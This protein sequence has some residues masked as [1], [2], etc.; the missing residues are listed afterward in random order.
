LSLRAVKSMRTDTRWTRRSHAVAGVGLLAGI[1]TLTGRPAGA[2]PGSTER[3]S[4]DSGGNQSVG[5]SFAG[6]F[7]SPPSI[8][9][10]G[11]F[12]AFAAWARNLAPGDTNGFGDVFVRDRGAGVT[13]RLSVDGAG[14]E[15]ND[16]IH[17]PALSADGRFV[18][19]VSAA[20]NLVPGDTN[21]QSD[22]FVHDRRT[23]TTER[24]SVASAGSEGSGWSDRPAI[25]AD[26]RFVAFV[27]AAPDLVPGD[28]NGRADVFVHDRQTRTTERVNVDS[29]GTQADGES[30]SPALSA[31]G[32]FVAFVS[33]ATNLVPGDTNGRADVFVHDR[34]TRTTERVSVDSAGTQAD[35][36]S[37]SPALS[38]DGRFVAFSSGATNLVPGDTNGQSDVFVHD[39]QTRAT[40]RVSVDSAGT[41]ADGWSDRPAIS[42]GGRF[43]AFC[44]FATNLM[45]G[46]TN[47]QWDEFVHDRQTR[48]TE[49]VSVD[50]AGTEANASSH[51]PSISAGGR[52]VVFAS[53]ATNLVPGDTNWVRDVFLHDRGEASGESVTS[54]G[55][56]ARLR[57]SALQGERDER[58]RGRRAAR[59]ASAR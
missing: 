45:A 28:T 5:P 8:S 58:A 57:Q 46:D 54:A 37:A 13:E 34:Q 7:A 25:S 36:E 40:E 32:R 55:Q 47:G 52:F 31:D 49:R 9:A 24:V 38:A 6:P 2:F 26:G 44:T 33:A 42:A 50:N 16:T 12:V 27:S 19:F 10:D 20:T 30:E 14:T 39:R 48:T 23:R 51:S 59:S 17:Q 21:G 15:A 29:A 22:V 56:R 35:R 18:A 11:R 43:V 1:L 41:E 53:D 3:V 4:V